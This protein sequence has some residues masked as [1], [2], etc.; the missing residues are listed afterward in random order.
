MS[1]DRRR[2]TSQQTVPAPLEPET[3]PSILAHLSSA[4]CYC[5]PFFAV[6][7]IPSPPSSSTIHHLSPPTVL[8][9]CSLSS[10]K[11]ETIQNMEAFSPRLS[12]LSVPLCV[13]R[14]VRGMKTFL[15]ETT[16]GVFN[17]HTV[18]PFLPANLLISLPTPLLVFV[19]AM[20]LIN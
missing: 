4:P 16:Q 15:K 5:L 17:I 20:V 3:T 7:S 12:L 9:I 11:E 13:F 2:M 1:R 14:H 19:S 8:L 18:R 6:Y 10:K